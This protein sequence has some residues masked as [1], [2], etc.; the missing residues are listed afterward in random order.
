MTQAKRWIVLCLATATLHLGA[1]NW[2]DQQLSRPPLA[3]TSAAPV[4]V[5]LRPAPPTPTATPARV[6]TP[7]T[8]AS[9]P[10]SPL[11]SPLPRPMPGPMPKPARRPAITSAAPP[12]PTPTPLPEPTPAPAPVAT[13]TPLPTPAAAPETASATPTLAEATP[14]PTP[15]PAERTDNKTFRANPLPSMELKYLV[16]KAKNGDDTGG[17]TEGS[18]SIR[19]QN[20]GQQYRIDGD[21]K[22]L[23]FTLFSFQSEGEITP[24]G[25][26]PLLYSEKRGTRSRTNTHFQRGKNVI[27]FSASTRE[28]P[29]PEGAQ[30]RASMLWQ[31]A[32]IG[33]ADNENLSTNSAIEFVVAGEKDADAWQFKLVG[34]ENLPLEGRAMPAWH[35][36]RT[37]ASGSFGSKIDVWL[38]PQH[39]WAP[40]RII[41]TEGDGSFIE[42]NMTKF[43][44][45]GNPP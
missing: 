32:A 19:W 2:A 6:L 20:L 28:F 43:T 1:L 3:R 4:Q 21:A 22:I 37:P 15:A 7:P 26:A 24:N 13:P 23:F 35:F 31:L 8:A 11:P 33:S 34:T 27:S 16:R 45:S 10:A 18:G 5:R 40:V 41:Q 38:S 9:P 29:R 25:I 44:L 36:V 12:A 42:M 17:G 39:E 14:T 30:D